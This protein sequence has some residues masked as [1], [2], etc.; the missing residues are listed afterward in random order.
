MKVRIGLATIG[1]LLIGVIFYI[2]SAFTADTS[3]P[4]ISL[5]HKTAVP[6]PTPIRSEMYMEPLS[7]DTAVGRRFD[8]TISIDAKN[9]VINGVDSIVS[10]DPTAIRVVQ[11]TAVADPTKTLTLMRRQIEDGKVYITAIKSEANDIPTQTLPVARLS[12]QALKSGTT[13]LMFEHNPTSTTGSTV[14]R[15]DGSENILD[16]I[17]SATIVVK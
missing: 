10:Y 11:V 4:L 16:K 13:T 2:I 17:T 14:I 15:A 8:V 12:V 9:T 7:I 6:T 3:A 1:A 5:P